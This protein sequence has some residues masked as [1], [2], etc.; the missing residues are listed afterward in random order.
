MAQGLVRII[1]S[2]PANRREGVPKRSPFE[3]EFEESISDPISG[4]K[5]MKRKIEFLSGIG[6]VAMLLTLSTVAQGGEITA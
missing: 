4:R 1:P 6:A 5:T 2:N 3:T